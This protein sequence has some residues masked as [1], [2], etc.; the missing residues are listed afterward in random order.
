MGIDQKVSFIYIIASLTNSGEALLILGNITEKIT[1]NY[2]FILNI[3]MICGRFEFIGYF[4]IFNRVLK[5]R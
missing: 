2:Y 3:L 5:F 1:P 4:L